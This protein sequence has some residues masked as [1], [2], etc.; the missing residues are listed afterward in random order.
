[1]KK[2][3]PCSVAIFSLISS[4]SICNAY[5]KLHELTVFGQKMY[6]RVYENNQK[7]SQ[8][9]VVLLSG[10]GTENPN[11]DFKYLIDEL[12]KNFKVVVLDYFG[13]GNSD[14][15]DRERSNKDIVDEFNKALEQLK[16]DKCILMPH[17][18]SGLYALYF[19]SNF[20][21]KVEAIVGIDM[22]LPQKQ[23]ERWSDDEAL[24]QCL[25]GMKLNETMT[26][27]WMWFLKNSKEL[28]KA[29]YPENLPVLAFIASGQIKD[30]EDMIIEKK[31]KTSWEKINENM[32]T[33]EKIQ[34]VIPLEGKH[35]LHYTQSAAISKTL[36]DF[37]LQHKI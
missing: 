27:Q 33:N 20:P 25:N 34:K 22:S 13:Y 5:Y 31:M 17:S 19:A 37:F 12:Q 15:T 23:I 6:A 36:N 11:N 10:F 4:V 3:L 16:I 14:E 24:G 35:Y 26:N 18:M 9:T 1:M 7:E 32:I 21:E 8:E 2:F 29:K 30:V 28:E